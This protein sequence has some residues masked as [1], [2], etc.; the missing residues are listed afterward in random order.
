MKARHHP[1]AQINGDCQHWP[2]NGTAKLFVDDDDVNKG[3]I[4]LPNDI[5][6]TGDELSRTWSRARFNVPLP[7]LAG[8]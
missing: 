2:P 4:N 8:G 3:V 7:P 6:S 1:S 5:G